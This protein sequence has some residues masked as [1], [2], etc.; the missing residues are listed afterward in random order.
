[1]QT[2]ICILGAASP[3]V[4]VFFVWTG[5][6]AP[7]KRF[8]KEYLDESLANLASLFVCLVTLFYA[9]RL[10]VESLAGLRAGIGRFVSGV[11]GPG[12]GTCDSIISFLM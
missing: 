7:L 2:I 8:L 5:I 1:M 9:V 3:L 10:S 11:V 6:R 12:L 4:V